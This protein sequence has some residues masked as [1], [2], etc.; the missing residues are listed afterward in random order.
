MNLNIK[1]QVLVLLA[2][3]PRLRDDDRALIAE[4]WRD[5]NGDQP[6]S[7]ESFLREFSAGKFAHPESIRRSR[8]ALQAKY[9]EL[10][11]KNYKERHDHSK[12]VVQELNDIK[13]DIPGFGGLFD[14]LGERFKIR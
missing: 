9:P 4:V 6:Q 1:D 7:F 5:Q 3:M 13:N 11:G 10:R 14:D 8:A 12:D 2:A